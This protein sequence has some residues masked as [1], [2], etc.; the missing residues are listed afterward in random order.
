MTVIKLDQS[1]RVK[2]RKKRRP[3]YGAEIIIAPVITKLNTPA[4]RILNAAVGKLDECVIIGLDKDGNEVAEFVYSPH[5]P[6]MSCGA[7]LILK[8]EYGVRPKEAEDE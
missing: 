1:K 2:K 7:R 8:A 4:D 5:K 3:K 6:I